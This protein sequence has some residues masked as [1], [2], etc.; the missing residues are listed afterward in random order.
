VVFSCPLL[1]AAVP[2]TKGRRYVVLTFLHDAEAHRGG[3]RARRSGPERA[4]G[5][6][7]CQPQ[8]VIRTPPPFGHIVNRGFRGEADSVKARVV[9]RT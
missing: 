9:Q 8:V 5:L 1:H 2:V 3:W 7:K 4:A 6:S